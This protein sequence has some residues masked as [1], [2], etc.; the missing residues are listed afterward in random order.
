[1]YPYV[2]EERQAFLKLFQNNLVV[3]HYLGCQT[4][5]HEWTDG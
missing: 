4:F 5:H 1:M 2:I 3:I